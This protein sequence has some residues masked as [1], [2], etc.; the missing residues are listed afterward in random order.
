MIDE[1]QKAIVRHIVT[2][3]VTSN[4]EVARDTFEIELSSPEIVSKAQPGQ[5][6]NI[7]ISS[8]WDPILRRPMSIAGIKEDELVLIYKVVGRGTAAMALWQPGERVNVL[9]PLGNGWEVL[10]DTYPV[11]VAG[12]VGL[13]AVLYLHAALSQSETPHHLIVGARTQPDHMLSHDPANGITLTTED[14]STGIR[15]TVMEGLESVIRSDNRH[16]APLSIY[17]CGPTAM[18]G[19]LRQYTVNEGFDCQLAL[20]EIMACGFGLCQGCSVP[21]A[22]SAT[23]GRPSYRERF[24][25][26]CVDGPVFKASELA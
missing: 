5:F 18:L 21:M 19:A 8:E 17:G 11:L 14:G 1:K 6:V 24:K 10:P 22:D 23:N 12:G 13:A 25:L 2:A 3:T 9:G 20:E 26:A 4:R 15:G 7:R 16:G